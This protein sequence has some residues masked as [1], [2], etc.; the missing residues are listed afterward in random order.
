M[1]NA[2]GKL[3]QW[4]ADLVELTSCQALPDSNIFVVCALPGVDF[5]QTFF[6]GIH[7]IKLEKRHSTLF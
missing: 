5:L 6:F 2:M 3:G 4:Q 7:Y 1:G